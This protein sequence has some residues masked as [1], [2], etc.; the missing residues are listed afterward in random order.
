MRK[1]PSS[2]S[3]AKG[4]LD[5]VLQSSR[6]AVATL[7]IASGV[8][9]I[10]T[11]TG[12][13]F[14]MQVYDRVLGSQSVPTLVG[15]SVIAFCAYAFQGWLEL[16]RGRILT[17]VGEKI[18]TELAPKV[19]DAGLK[20]ALTSPTG[21]GEANQALRDVEAIRGFVA[22]NGLAT[23]F[24]L[25]WIPIYVLLLSFLHPL[26]GIATLVSALFLIAL[27]WRTE[28]GSHVAVKRA[29]E[30]GVKRNQ[31]VD[32]GLRS[33]EAITANGM[34]AAMMRQWAETHSSYLQAQRDSTFVIG[35]YGAV[36]RTS[37]MVVQSMMLAL[38]AYLA[39][40]GL[41]TGGAIIAAS[42][43]ASRALA[44]IDQAIASWRPFTAARDGYRRLAQIL[45]RVPATTDR[46]R[47][48]PP[49]RSITLEQVAIAPPGAQRPSLHNVSL[50]LKAGQGLGIV[51]SSAS[52]KS[53]LVRGIVNAWRPAAGRIR[54]DEADLSQWDSDELGK[55]IGYLPQDFQLFEGTVAENIARFDPGATEEKVQKAARAAGLD[56]YIR[57]VIGG[58]DKPIGAGGAFLSAGQ[59][60]RIGLARALYGDPFLVVLDEPNSNLDQDGET[61]LQLAMRGIR[62]RGG[63]VIVVAHR[64]QVLQEVDMV[65]ALSNGT[66]AAF[67]PRQEVARK[68]QELQ[69]AAQQQ[70]GQPAAQPP[71]PTGVVVP[72]KADG[73]GAVIGERPQPADQR[74]STTPAH[75]VKSSETRE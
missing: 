21:V 64:Q 61:A 68:L 59:R 12:S 18:D 70:A 36:A 42:I 25:P 40:Q 29:M 31:A 46:F 1:A 32:A 15:L 51:G 24:D 47:L 54:I 38:G 57:R 44:P 3:T 41:L 27:T 35:G 56:D 33:A 37:R 62:Q 39:I 49:H 17:L 6:R 13:I 5:D 11:L 2:A 72:H 75:L 65:L 69:R 73:K 34:R 66:T 58:Y 60:Q 67:G 26:F 8:I 19:Q 14:M 74:W 71:G 50:T 20:L 28:R 9:N 53:T 43:I 52:G 63:I 22:S 23:A 48:D 7:A 45:T 16:M 55:Y 4:L 30:L 10:L